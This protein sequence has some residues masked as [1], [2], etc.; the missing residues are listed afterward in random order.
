[1]K[2]ILPKEI[3]TAEEAIILLT[4]LYNNNEAYHPEDKAE[5][6]IDHMCTI[7]ECMELNEIMKQ[8]YDL[9]PSF[10]PCDWLLYVDGMA[11]GYEPVKVKTIEQTLTGAQFEVTGETG[12]DG[13]FECKLIKK[14]DRQYKSH[15]RLAKI[16]EVHRFHTSHY[17]SG[18]IFNK[19]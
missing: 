12:T 4:A 1:M 5:D 9:K 13:Y 11:E 14:A 15:Y 6:C 2:T 10:D 17:I 7:E 3:K 16:G 8:I 19:S 18:A